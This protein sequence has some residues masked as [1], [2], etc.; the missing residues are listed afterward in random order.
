[1][2]HSN[3]LKE[4]AKF[5]SGLVIGDMLAALWAIGSDLLP[6]RFLGVPITNDLAWLG[7]AFDLFLFIMLV[8]YAWHPHTLEPKTSGQTLFFVVGV[9]T[10]LVALAHLVRLA[11]GW[12]VAIGN[13]QMPLWFSG[14]AFIV[15]AYVSY[16]S[17]HFAARKTTK[18][19]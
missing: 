19:G 12:T 7:V 9:L 4:L 16:A 10:G 14:A 1:M 18:R 3:K 2:S 5:A 6:V 8:H 11:F 13:W 15:T 17:F